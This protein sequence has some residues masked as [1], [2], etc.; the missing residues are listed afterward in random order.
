MRRSSDAFCPTELNILFY[1]LAPS[2]QLPRAKSNKMR[3]G[4]HRE[5]R[6]HRSSKLTKQPP[7]GNATFDTRMSQNN[8]PAQLRRHPSVPQQSP[9]TG[10]NGR[11]NGHQ[12]HFQSPHTSSDSSLDRSPN[13]ASSKFGAHTQPESDTNVHSYISRKSWNEKGS[14]DVNGASYDT[15]SA[16][17]NVN[18]IKS[19]GYQNP[20]RRPGPPPL[21]HTSPDTRMTSP[22]L[23]QSASFSVGDC[24]GD[25]TPP[26]S[27]AGLVTPKRYSDEANGGRNAALWKKKSGFSSFMN[28]VLG[29]P[30]TVKISHPENPV[31][32]THVGFD[33]DTGQFTVRKKLAYL[34]VA[35]ASFDYIIYVLIIF[36]LFYTCLQSRVRRRRIWRVV[37][38]IYR[39][40]P[41]NG[42]GC[43]RKA[44]YQRTSRSRTLKPSLTS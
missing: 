1:W 13:L 12:Q 4:D 23:R 19:S 37:L 42:N 34:S 3:D 40:C 11:E 43:S 44:V 2:Y 36:V 33:N 18:S 30:R 28:S 38:T 35:V 14:N 10:L 9:P 39:G 41:G 6:E 29:S 21:S 22:A 32:V 7:P 24:S 17:S 15:L 20:L 8:N 25:V 5:H 27:D 31:H 16:L 26:R